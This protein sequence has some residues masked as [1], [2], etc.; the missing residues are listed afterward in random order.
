MRSAKPGASTSAVELANV[1][2]HGLWLLID[3]REHYLPF[4][5]FPWVRDATIRQLSRI[6]R[7]T[8]DHLYWPELD[9]DLTLD[10]IEHPEDHPLECRTRGG[11]S[12]GGG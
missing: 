1:S 6:E 10:S 11:R 12:A 2:Q 5:V 8:R 4:D 3:A 9:V 7:P